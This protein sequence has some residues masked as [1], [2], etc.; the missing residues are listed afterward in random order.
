[1]SAGAQAPRWH[2]APT[3]SPKPLLAGSTV[4]ATVVRGA[5]HVLTPHADGSMVSHGRLDMDDQLELLADLPLRSVSGVAAKG[6][7]MLVAG[8]RAGD[9]LPVVGSVAAAGELRG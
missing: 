3:T 7:A 1:M 6:D 8:A 4:S 9:N 5:L 2:W